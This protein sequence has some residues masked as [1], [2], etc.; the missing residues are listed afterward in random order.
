MEGGR[1]GEGRDRLTGCI[2]GIVVVIICSTF[3]LILFNC[4][5]VTSA[6]TFA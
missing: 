2:C 3:A 4:L 6:G 5:G 1:E